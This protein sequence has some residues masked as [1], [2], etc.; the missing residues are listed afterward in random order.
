M[1]PPGADTVL[2]RYGE[3]GVKSRAVQSRMEQRLEGNIGAVLEARS[4]DARL[5]REHTRLFVETDSER[6]DAVT[7][8]ITDTFGVVSA[9]PAKRVEPTEDEIIDCLMQTARSVYDGN[10][11]AVRVHRAGE[12][13]RHP[14][15]SLELERSGGAAVCEALDEAGF[16]PT[17]DLDD[18]EWT[19]SVECRP[20]D[21]YVFCEKHPGP[22]GLPVGSQ[23]PVVT[24]VSGGIDSP[25][26]AWHLLKRGCPVVPLY[27]DLGQY[28]GV[29]HRAR[30]ERTV[31]QLKRFA[32]NFDLNLRVASGGE[33]IERIHEAPDRFGMLLLRR[34]MLRVAAAVADDVGAVGI[35]TGEAIGQKSSQTSAN[36][37]V[38]D[39][40][41]EYPV[42]RPLLSMDKSTVTEVAKDI[43]THDDA[44]VQ[45]GCNR[46]APD[47]PA[48]KPDPTAVS[49]AEPDDIEA[50][51]RSAAR[52]R[53][54]I[55]FDR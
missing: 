52:E 38:T 4:L 34:F 40:A 32:P 48:T 16:E 22:G 37:R 15:T 55:R 1:H 36:L 50:L 25:V 6:I 20:D 30:A 41:V 13:D 44:T 31:E 17:V 14:F 42:H 46:L 9:S 24:L 39:A 11:L 26:A 8:A 2:V 27:I 28:G 43:G 45:A 47:N 5:R 51:A 3:I 33:G 7:D 12:A 35:A 21:A 29:D 23:E 49:E 18:P 54:V 19:F 53:T 10:S